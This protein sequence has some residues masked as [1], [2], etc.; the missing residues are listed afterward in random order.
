MG[1]VLVFH[2]Q[3]G[4]S[5][6]PP[7]SANLSEGVGGAMRDVLLYITLPVSTYASGLGPGNSELFYKSR[8]GE[9]KPKK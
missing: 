2:T 9:V 4:W 5:D 6:S 8:N 1:A 3:L 7:Y